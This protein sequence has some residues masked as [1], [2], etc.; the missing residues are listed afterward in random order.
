MAPRPRSI[1]WFERAYVLAIAVNLLNIY[2]SWDQMIAQVEATPGYAGKG[3]ASMIW[4]LAFW[5]PINL[6][7]WYLAALRHSNPARW[8]IVGFAIFNLFD[9]GTI[10]LLGSLSRD[11]AGLLTLAFYAP[12]LLAVW[13]L[14]RP[15]SQGWF[16]GRWSDDYPDIFK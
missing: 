7:L 8:L 4:T 15:D 16:E 12:S 11:L 3:V 2:L 6:L 13:F 10:V 5:M 1:L 14:F 9:L